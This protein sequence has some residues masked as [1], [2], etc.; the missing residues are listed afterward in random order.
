MAEI[1]LS[2]S[3]GRDAVVSAESVTVTTQ[4][5]W[6]DDSGA[7]VG[8]RK[9]LRSTL[10]HDIEALEK[11]YSDDPEKIAEALIEGDPEVDLEDFGSYLED[12]S[13]VYVDPD[14]NIVH[15]VTLYEVVRDPQGEVKERRPKKTI[16]PNVSTEVPLKWTGK[17]FPKKAIYKKFV[18][19]GKMQIVHVNGL[20]YDFL[21]EMAE[22]LESENAMMLV[23]GGSKGNQPLMFRR[24]G[25]SYRG[26]LEGRTEGKKYALILHLTNM[27][28][29]AVE[30]PEPEAK[31]D[32]KGESA[33]PDKDAA[34]SAKPKA[35]A[36][37]APAKEEKA[38]EK[39]EPKPEPKQ[40]EEA[41]KAAKKKAPAKKKSATTKK[42]AKKKSAAK[43]TAP[44]EEKKP[45][46]AKKKAA[47]KK[48]PAKK[49][50]TKKAAK[51]KTAKKKT[52]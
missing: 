32:D 5:R 17:K 46:P 25:L 16:E 11:E 19:S 31:A 9:I 21:Y 29:K 43:D 40:E 48:A 1:N 4:M 33:K 13:R 38:K 3:K 49:A 34:K 22:T 15:K 47:T 30:R 52:S 14:K 45:A 37:P 41:P 6:I 26:F 36:N 51:K 24:G 20:T 28:L 50:A 35:E 8:T 18:F 2:D 44:A 7:Q 23:A 27:E 42:T 39:E 10:P 12:T